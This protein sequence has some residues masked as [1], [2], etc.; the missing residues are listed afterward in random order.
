MWH[1]CSAMLLATLAELAG[2]GM[3]LYGFYSVLKV[4]IVAK[5]LIELCTESTTRSCR[6]L[7]T[8]V[9]NLACIWV[10]YVTVFYD[11]TALV[12]L[13]RLIV[14]ASRLHSDTP[15]S[16]GL[17]F[18]SDQPF[19]ETSTWQHTTLTTNRHPC[20]QAGFE[21]AV[22]SSERPKTD[23]LDRAVAGIGI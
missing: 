15:H 5:H 20:P 18:T 14:E 13:S 23:A 4:R 21:P 17:L 8:L 2:P 7:L 3:S 9:P 22:P 12:G 16:V 19:A 1:A 11:S 10:L 6:C